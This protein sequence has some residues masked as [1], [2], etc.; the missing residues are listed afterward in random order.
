MT[1]TIV[2]ILNRNAQVLEQTSDLDNS[3]FNSSD[4]GVFAIIKTNIN[5]TN[6]VY[7]SVPQRAA[8]R[9]LRICRKYRRYV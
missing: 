2:S 7:H 1:V 6:R 5:L 3:V 8:L 4:A 9:S